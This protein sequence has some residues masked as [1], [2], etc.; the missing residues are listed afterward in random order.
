MCSNVFLGLFPVS[1]KCPVMIFIRSSARNVTEES[2]AELT[3]SM[4]EKDGHCSDFYVRYMTTVRNRRIYRIVS[5]IHDIFLA[6][7]GVA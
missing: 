1:S 7:F 5:F 6:V 4:L 3:I 2:Q